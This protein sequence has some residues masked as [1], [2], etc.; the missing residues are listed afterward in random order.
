MN[1][2]VLIGRLVADP[3]FKTLQ[4][5]NAVANMRIAVDRGKNEESDFIDLSAFGKTA[6]FASNY[7]SKGRLIAIQGKLRVRQYEHNGEKRKAAEVV[8]DN[9]QPLDSKKDSSGAQNAY[10]AP[11][12]RQSI[13]TDD[14]TDPFG[15]D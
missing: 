1:Q 10:Q 12:Q 2:V 8:V 15:D 9:I 11:Q 14:L 3:D 7:L 6:E 4:S 5:G 13:K